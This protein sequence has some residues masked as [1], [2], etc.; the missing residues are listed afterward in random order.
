MPIGLMIFILS[1]V[2]IGITAGP[3]LGAPRQDGNRLAKRD[4][5]LAPGEAQM[6]EPGRDMCR[7]ALVTLDR[8]G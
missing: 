1:F 2:L 5:L 4:E 8:V 7:F 6:P 3:A